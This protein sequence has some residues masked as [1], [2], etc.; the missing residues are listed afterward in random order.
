MSQK[1]LSTQDL[2]CKNALEKDRQKLSKTLAALRQEQQDMLNSTRAKIDDLLDKEAKKWGLMIQRVIRTTD[3][4]YG[5]LLW[6]EVRNEVWRNRVEKE[7]RAEYS[8]YTPNSKQKEQELEEPGAELSGTQYN[9][10]KS[11]FLLV[12]ATSFGGNNRDVTWE[13]ASWAFLLPAV[14][15][16]TLE[17]YPDYLLKEKLSSEKISSLCSLVNKPEFKGDWLEYCLEVK[18]IWEVLLLP[19]T[20]GGTD[21]DW[22]EVLPLEYDKVQDRSSIP[23]YVESMRILHDE[24]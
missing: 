4:T 2:R 8:G 14:L 6:Q 21:P 15:E 13:M 23:E 1:N 7:I 16:P 5:H 18:E 9:T 19:Q 20:L 24:N 10:I 11:I 3:S 17:S 12:S 22:E